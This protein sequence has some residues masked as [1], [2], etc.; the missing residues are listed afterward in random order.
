MYPR[1]TQSFARPRP[2]F[3]QFLLPRTRTLL[4]RTRPPFT[5]CRLYRTKNVDSPSSITNPKP[6]FAPSLITPGSDHHNSLPTF[7]AYAKRTN[8]SQSSTVYVGTHYEYLVQSALTRLN[9]TL[10]RT[11]SGNDHGIDLL[12]HWHVPSLPASAPMRVLLQCKARSAPLGPSHVRELE[13][14]FAGAPAGWRGEGVLGLLVAN[15][16]ATRGMR[17]ALG[18]SGLPLGY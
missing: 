4:R 9:F 8:L 5:R 3:D 1:A 11:G 10:T 13:G 2:A 16:E 17:E 18:R 15:R 6:K 14:A 12:G 7:I